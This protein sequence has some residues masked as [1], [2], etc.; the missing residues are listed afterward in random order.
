MDFVGLVALPLEK[1]KPEVQTRAGANDTGMLL[2]R[3]I[4]ANRTRYVNS[5]PDLGQFLKP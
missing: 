2:A 3:I 1:G 4:V 5:I